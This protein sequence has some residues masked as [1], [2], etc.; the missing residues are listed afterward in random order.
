MKWSKKNV[1]VNLQKAECAYVLSFYRPE[2]RESGNKHFLLWLPSL[3]KLDEQDLHFLLQYSRTLTEIVVVVFRVN[4]HSASIRF[5][6]R[7][8][9]IQYCGSG[10]LAA[11]GWLGCNQ[12]AFNSSGTLFTQ[13][14]I[15]FSLRFL[16]GKWKVGQLSS[17][18]IE[19]LKC[20]KNKEPNQF[21]YY[22]KPFTSRRLTSTEFAIWSTMI[23]VPA[24]E[25]FVIGQQK[26]YCHLV[27]SDEQQLRQLVVRERLI[28]LL[29]QRA[30][31]VTSPS[32]P[33]SKTHYNLR[34]FAPQYGMPEDIATGSAHLQVAGYWQQRLR[35][36]RVL[37][38][39]LI[40]Q[41]G[42]FSIERCS[43]GCSS[44]RCSS[45]D[46]RSFGYSANQKVIGHVRIL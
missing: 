45:F 36:K 19:K 4:S 37:G 35:K 5:F 17:P 16:R 26:D 12:S 23:S 11:A 1:P 21:F 20:V 9:E 44:V 46:Y 40:K 7:G 15:D 30:L 29:K 3:N 43:V 41:G 25:G 18:K 39:Q 28:C 42:A 22:A 8:H 33:V 24:A 2:D 31:I 6:Q 34:Y 38:R 32:S 10:T 14:N 27:V 13:C